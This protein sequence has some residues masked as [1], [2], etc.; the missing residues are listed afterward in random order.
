M[1]TPTKASRG[2]LVQRNTER[3][4]F[5]FVA[6][7]QHLHAALFFYRNRHAWR[8][9]LRSFSHTTRESGHHLLKSL[10]DPTSTS[11]TNR[12]NNRN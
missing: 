4:G 8:S 9:S 11:S 3:V 7:K 6:N 12:N 10:L 1:A 5:L 2:L